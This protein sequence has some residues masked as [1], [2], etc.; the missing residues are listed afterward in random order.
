[1]NNFHCDD[2]HYIEPGRHGRMKRIWSDKCTCDIC[3]EKRLCVCFDSSDD[4][5]STIAIC[6]DCF[7]SLF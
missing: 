6:F 2:L 7:R 1:M 3:E 5:Y 4:E